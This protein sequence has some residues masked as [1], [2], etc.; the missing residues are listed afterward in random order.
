MELGD[1]ISTIA[2]FVTHAGI[3]LAIHGVFDERTDVFRLGEPSISIASI[4]S[5]APGTIGYVP[6]MPIPTLWPSGEQR[7]NR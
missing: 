2:A 5:I 7:L 6:P 3:V 1:V 4:A